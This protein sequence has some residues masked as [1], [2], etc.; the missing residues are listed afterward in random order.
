MLGVPC[1]CC[2]ERAQ[3]IPLF[4]SE[5]EVLCRGLS[6]RES[7]P[8]CMFTLFFLLWHVCVSVH[9]YLLVVFAH[10]PVK[11]KVLGTHTHLPDAKELGMEPV[12]LKHHEFKRIQ[13][14]PCPKA[15]FGDFGH[16]WA[17]W[18]GREVYMIFCFGALSRGEQAKGGEFAKIPCRVSANRFA[19][20]G[21]WVTPHFL[22][23][24]P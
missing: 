13:L 10:F 22:D 7:R 14:S 8:K 6:H 2:R 21:R 11:V 3:Y 18:T 5:K 20:F 16:G 19:P 24:M 1:V 15:G 4:G 9:L 17:H 23:R 12:V